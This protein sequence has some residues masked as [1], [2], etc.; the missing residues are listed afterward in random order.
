MVKRETSN[1]NLTS[2]VGIIDD[3][4]LVMICEMRDK[5]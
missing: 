3:F 1:K 2:E 5:S 4:N